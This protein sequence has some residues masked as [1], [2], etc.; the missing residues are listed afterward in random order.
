MEVIFQ[1]FCLPDFQSFENY[2]G[3]YLSRPKNVTK[4]VLLISSYLNN[5]PVRSSSMEVVFQILK[6][7]KIVLVCP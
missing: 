4:L 6:I 7:S 5:L 2:F 3:L 1:G